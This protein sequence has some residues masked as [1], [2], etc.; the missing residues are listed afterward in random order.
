MKNK[1]VHLPQCS[2][3][4]VSYLCQVSEFLFLGFGHPV[5]LCWD[6]TPLAW[7]LDP[8]ARDGRRT[9]RQPKFE[10]GCCKIILVFIVCGARQK[11]K[12]TPFYTL[13]AG[14]PRHGSTEDQP[15]SWGEKHACFDHQAKAY[16]C[17]AHGLP[18]L[19]HNVQPA[20]TN[21]VEEDC[22]QANQDCQQAK[23]FARPD[24]VL[25]QELYSTRL[26]FQTILILTH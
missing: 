6:R 4:L 9:F 25:Q 24:P 11:I 14:L 22:Q 10:C 18:W 21:T 15:S 19:V 16:L 17:Y 1:L 12:N 13:V 23:C 3:T 2:D 7:G 5:L 26:L 8:F 20:G